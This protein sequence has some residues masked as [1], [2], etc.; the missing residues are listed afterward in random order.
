MTDPLIHIAELAEEL[1]D[2]RQHTERIFGWRNR[3]RVLERI[4]ITTQAGLLTQLRTA[5]QPAATTDE[6][7]SAVPASRPPLLIEAL[8]RHLEIAMRT[9]RWIHHTRLP[10]RGQP[11]HNIRALV[12]AVHTLTSD[13]QHALRADLRQWRS[14]AAVLSGWANPPYCPHVPCP[15]PD[16]SK[17]GTLRIII[18]RHK[19]MCSACGHIWDDQDGSINLLATYITEQTDRPHRRVPVRADA[20]GHGGWSENKKSSTA[21]A[22]IDF[23]DWVRLT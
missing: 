20:Q 3:N 6:T 23:P 5:I 7:G 12:G 13:E 16:C 4:H 10:N 1:C 22:R 8:S 2:P 21:G 18:D 14:W 17:L 11:E 15:N 9:N 19:G